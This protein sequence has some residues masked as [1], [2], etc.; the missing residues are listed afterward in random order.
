MC[1]NAFMDIL[2]QNVTVLDGSGAPAYAG[3]IGMENG[4]LRM[5]KPCEAAALS[6]EATI[7]G[8]GLTAVP[9]FIDAHS[10]G[11]LTMR[12]VYAPAR[13]RRALPRRSRGNAVFPCSPVRRIR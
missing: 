1:Y 7:D 11:D 4:K 12:G 2:I 8:T 3:A 9:G 10:H 6:A 5:F 13:S